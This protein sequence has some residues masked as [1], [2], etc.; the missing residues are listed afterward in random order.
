MRTVVEGMVISA[1]TDA[2]SE[3]LSMLKH[4]LYVKPYVRSIKDKTQ[5]NRSDDNV[6]DIIMLRPGLK[7]YQYNVEYEFCGNGV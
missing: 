6:D 3:N 1:S 5:N 2:L 7:L 4:G